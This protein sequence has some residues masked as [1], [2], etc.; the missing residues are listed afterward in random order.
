MHFIDEAKIY[1]KA[2]DGGP[3]CVSFRREKFIEFGGPN[4]G[5]GGKGGSV[6]FE[7]TD[8]LNTLIDFR[9]KQHFKVRN[10]EG[11]KGRNMYGKSSDDMVIKVPV[12]TQVFSEDGSELLYDLIEDGQK[13]LVVK[14]G[15]GGFGNTHFK[16]S[17]NQ[18]PRRA[19]PGYPGAEIWVWLKLKLLSD[20]GLVG[21][22]NAGKSTF[23]SVSSS[24]KPKIADYPFTTLKPQLGVVYVD[25]EEF[26]LADLPGLIEGASQG[27]GLGDR[28]LK[29]VER[30]GIILHLIDCSSED[31]IASYDLIR[32]ELREYSA[33]LINKPEIIVL[34]KADLLPQDEIDERKKMLEKHSKN[35]VFVCSSAMQKGVKEIHSHALK[36]IRDRLEEEF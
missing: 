17:V 9:Y 35:K 31:L 2:G 8:D 11:G 16:S 20:A 36:V 7:A 24:A 21:L 32:N 26:V 15:D 3:G 14:G 10:G 34:T 23:L 13:V 4:G 22:P 29:H 1:L 6:Y 12:G 25:E 18:A 28:F 30:C 33:D 5:D 19:T 27:L